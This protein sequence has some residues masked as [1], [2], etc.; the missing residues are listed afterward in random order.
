M[1]MP[2]RIN[3][4]NSKISTFIWF[5]FTL[6]KR[7][8]HQLLLYLVCLIWKF[9]FHLFYSTVLLVSVG[10]VFRLVNRVAIQFICDIY[11][12]LTLELDCFLSLKTAKYKKNRRTFHSFIYALVFVSVRA[13]LPCIHL[14]FLFLNESNEKQNETR[15][16]KEKTWIRRSSMFSLY[17]SSSSCLPI[18]F[19]W[20]RE[21]D[22]TKQDK[23]YARVLYCSIRLIRSPER[24]RERESSERVK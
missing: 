9:F 22:S 20:W 14:S 5:Y 19:I 17:C 2:K 12:C 6:L 11:I 13:T 7:I 18:C 8:V 21:I 16:D 23:N 3:V 15:Q 4:F 24:E 1:C 10:V